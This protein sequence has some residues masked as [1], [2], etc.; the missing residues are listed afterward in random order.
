MGANWP[1]QRSNLVAGFWFSHHPIDSVGADMERIN[2][3]DIRR[4]AK[5]FLDL[6]SACKLDLETRHSLHSSYKGNL[7]SPGESDDCYG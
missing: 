5:H 3:G 6:D 7:D 2:D 1:H 4:R